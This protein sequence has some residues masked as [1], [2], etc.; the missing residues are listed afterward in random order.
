MSKKHRYFIIHP[1]SYSY[2]GFYKILDEGFRIA[3]NFKYKKVI[4]FPFFNFNKFHKIKN[5]YGKRLVFEIFM[6]LSFNEKL[7]TL[8][9]T[10]ILNINLSLKKIKFLGFLGLFIKS[11][12]IKKIFPTHF[13]FNEDEEYFEANKEIW[14]EINSNKNYFPIKLSSK[15]FLKDN[16][17]H[18]EKKFIC[19]HIKDKNY[20]FVNE[21]S[22]QSTS[23]IEDHQKAIE[24]FIDLDYS[25]VRIGD[26]YS[27]KF[28]FVNNKFIDLTKNKSLSHYNQAYTMQNSEFF[29]GNVTPGVYMSR[30]FGK[31]FA[32]TNCPQEDLIYNGFSNN[33]GNYAIFKDIFNVEQKRIIS[34]SE[35]LKNNELLF[36][37]RFDKKKFFLIDNT[38]G[39]IL[40]LCKNFV[41]SNFQNIQ[42]KNE[43][44]NEFN[45]L[46]KKTLD[47]YLSKKDNYN[48][49]LLKQNYYSKISLPK[50]YLE[51]RLYPN[52]VL[53]EK[54]KQIVKKLGI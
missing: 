45:L 15:K 53:I 37:R 32:L 11:N 42:E 49:L 30:L 36:M 18:L 19:M 13:G 46:R 3:D 8:F 39:E 44:L 22:N 29:F 2:T 4:C 38:P 17:N 5:I 25:V 7:L 16:S 10:V 12:I 51:E 20:N 21:I 14:N 41:K 35:L 26:K 1:R 28:D 9:Y 24:Y 31:K 52:D 23:R 47:I 43:L 54:S 50:K 34:I 48:Y 40:D 6:N 27:D 33:Y